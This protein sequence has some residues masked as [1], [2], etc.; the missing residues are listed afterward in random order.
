MSAYF[1]SSIELSS[2]ET[3]MDIVC[4]QWS[5]TLME[6]I[7]PEAQWW[8]FVAHAEAEMCKVL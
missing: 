5:L 8:H 1:I 2:A 6:E 4:P 3:I 7:D